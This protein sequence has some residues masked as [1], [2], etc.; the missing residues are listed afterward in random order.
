M[1]IYLAVAFLQTLIKL[2]QAQRGDAVRESLLMKQ[3]CTQIEGFDD[4]VDEGR[5]KLLTQ[6]KGMLR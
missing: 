1:I 6:Q 4:W 5:R 3:V 2:W